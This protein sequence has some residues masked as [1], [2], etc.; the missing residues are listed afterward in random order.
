MH[1]R[2]EDQENGFLSGEKMFPPPHAVLDGGEERKQPEMRLCI[3]NH[4]VQTNGCSLPPSPSPSL[5]SL[6]SARF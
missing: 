5:A 3:F 1:E 2:N 4:I 6:A